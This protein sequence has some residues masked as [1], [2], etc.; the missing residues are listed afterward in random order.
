MSGPS[1]IAIDPSGDVWVAN[2]LTTAG[3][4]TATGYS[5]TEL[6]GVA[7]PTYV[8]LSAATAA[9]KLGAKP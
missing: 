3:G 6:I 2:T 7:A 9:G 8:P 1:A 4:G 5:V